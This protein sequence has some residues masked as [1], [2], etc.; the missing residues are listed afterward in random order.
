[1]STIWVYKPAHLEYFVAKQHPFGFH[2]PT[3]DQSGRTSFN[4]IQGIPMPMPNK[5]DW[6]R[7]EQGLAFAGFDGKIYQITDLERP[8]FMSPQ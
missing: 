5:W 7:S 1:M 3:L 2:I 6:K 4:I 8:I